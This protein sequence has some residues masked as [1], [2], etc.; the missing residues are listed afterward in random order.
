M[1]IASAP[2]P[3]GGAMPASAPSPAPFGEACPL[4]GAPLHPEQGWCL[5]CGA[6]ARTRLAASP[7]WKAPVVAFAVVVALSLG[8]LAAALVD[9]AGGSGSSAPATTTTVTTSAAVAPS[10]AQGGLV[11]GASTSASGRSGTLTTA[12]TVRRAST[13]QAFRERLRELEQGKTSA[14]APTK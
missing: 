3:A 14:P 5:R 9:L 11:S 6:A 10:T 2:P 7:N 12:K 13:S 4:C 1:S 8:V